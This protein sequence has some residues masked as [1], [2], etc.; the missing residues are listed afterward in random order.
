[1]GRR[2]M[3]V[4]SGALTLTT[5][6]VMAALITQMLNVSCG[7]DHYLRTCSADSWRVLAMTSQHV[8]IIAL[9]WH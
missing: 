2:D 1:M 8:G 3:A 9:A 7:S 6:T 5:T 4:I